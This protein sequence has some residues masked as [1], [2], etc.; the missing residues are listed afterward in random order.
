MVFATQGVLE[1][2]ERERSKDKGGRGE[3]VWLQEL[4]DQIR[5]GRLSEDNWH[6]LHGRPTLVPGT[7]AR[8]TAQCGNV[9]ASF[10]RRFEQPV[11]LIL[12]PS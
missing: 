7:W 6:F 10:W 9:L 3:D 12:K 11:A 4:Q 8:G 2:E 1:V 5:N